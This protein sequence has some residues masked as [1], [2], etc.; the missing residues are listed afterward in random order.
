MQ[1]RSVLTWAREAESAGMPAVQIL[2]FAPF[3][4]RVECGTGGKLRFPAGQPT[5]TWTMERFLAL[6]LG[7]IHRLHDDENGYGPNG[8]GFLPHMEI[9][10]PVLESFR[11]VASSS[12][13][14]LAVR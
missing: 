4:P 13:A 5:E 3:V 11:R 2:S 14:T 1:R 12:L 9:P 7:E 10:E 6:I 8:Q